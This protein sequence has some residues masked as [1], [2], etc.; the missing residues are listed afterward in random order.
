M[1]ALNV[2]TLASWPGLASGMIVATNTSAVGTVLVMRST[3]VDSRA[4]APATLKFCRMSLVPMCSSTVRGVV[5]RSQVTMLASSWS[6]RQPG[7]PWWSWSP[8]PA[9]PLN[10]EPTK[11]TR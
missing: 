6:M 7:C 8:R 5:F 1:V 11:S 2:R 10:C 9:G 4:G 3:S